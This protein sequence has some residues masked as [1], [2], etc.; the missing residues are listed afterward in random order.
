MSRFQ[1]G[2]ILPL[3]EW[4]AVSH[5]R[6]TKGKSWVQI[7]RSHSAR[8]VWTAQSCRFAMHNIRKI[9]PFLTEHATQLFVQ[10]LVISRLDTMLFWPDSLVALS[11]LCKWFKMQLHTC[12]W[13]PMSLKEPTSHLCLF[14]CTSSSLRHWCLPIEQPRA[15]H[16][17]TSTLS[18]KFTS[19]SRSLQLFNK[20]HPLVPS[21]RDTKSLSRMFFLAGGMIFLNSFQTAE[22]II[23]LKNSWKRK[24]HLTVSC[25]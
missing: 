8:P 17:P 23:L 24:D 16:L 2:D 15:R 22:S 14:L 13:S 1:P 3:T 12:N 19:R 18:Y 25:K 20:R 9:R 10:A 21:Q 7:I 11:K 6:S 4:P 5:G